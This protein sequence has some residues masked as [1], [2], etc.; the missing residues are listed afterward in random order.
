V[1]VAGDNLGASIG[2]FKRRVA[3]FPLRP[4]QVTVVNGLG[5]LKSSSLREQVFIVLV[6]LR[7]FTV[8][9]IVLF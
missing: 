9:S 8:R 5:P 1:F 2:R 3:L 4:V 6:R 7:D